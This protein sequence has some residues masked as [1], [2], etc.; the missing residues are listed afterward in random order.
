MD[1]TNNFSEL[2]RYIELKLMEGYEFIDIYEKLEEEGDWAPDSIHDA[3][4]VAKKN[5][6]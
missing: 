3:H 6:E 4:Y 5:L 2:V 1:Y